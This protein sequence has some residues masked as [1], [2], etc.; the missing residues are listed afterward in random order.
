M[1]R[2]FGIF[3]LV[4]ML[5]GAVGIYPALAFSHGGARGG[6]GFH[7]A[8]HGGGFHGGP[9]HVI[10]GSRAFVH[11][12]GFVGPRVFVG[13]GFYPYYG[14]PYPYVYTDPSVVVTPSTAYAG[15][16]WY[17]CQNPAGYYPQ[18]AACPTGWLQVAP[19][20]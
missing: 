12:R 20:Q 2:I 7:G 1:K 9:A 5:V 8:V 14:Y 11:P 10:V 15:Q 3:A 13:P 17:Y 6:G 19:G 4:A 18:V 16:Y